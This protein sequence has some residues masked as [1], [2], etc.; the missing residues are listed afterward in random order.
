[1][2][3]PLAYFP[4]NW[5]GNLNSIMQLCIMFTNINLV[6]NKYGKIMSVDT[7]SKADSIEQHNILIIL[8]DIASL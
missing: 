5:Q 6:N 7:P 2:K 1:M 4:E 3:C 8:E